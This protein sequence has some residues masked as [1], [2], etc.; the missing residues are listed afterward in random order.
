MVVRGV[1]HSYHPCYSLFG[2]RS[3]AIRS[4]NLWEGRFKFQALL[5]E[6]V[7]MA[8]TPKVSDHTSVK[9][10]CEKV[11]ASKKPNQIN[12]QEKPLYPFVGNSREGQPQGIQMKLNDYLEL[13][14]SLVSS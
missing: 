5:D 1:Y 14:D 13:V 7:L 6:T 9:K 10:R 11:N 4:C 3:Y 8:N 2:Q 12:Q